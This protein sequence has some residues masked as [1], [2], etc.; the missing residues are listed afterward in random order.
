MLNLS[1][2]IFNHFTGKMFSIGS[3]R[4]WSVYKKI[5]NKLINLISVR[6]LKLFSVFK[7][8]NKLCLSHF[9]PW[10]LKKL[11]R[12]LILDFSLSELRAPWTL[13]SVVFIR[14]SFSPSSQICV[15]VSHTVTHTSISDPG[16][17]S[18]FLRCF[19]KRTNWNLRKNCVKTN[20]YTRARSK[21]C[22]SVFSA[23]LKNY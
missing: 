17:V 8:I 7:N 4:N 1:F 2:L 9:K 20:P 12:V 3:T 11:L 10:I 6:T 18:E 13:S 22:V 5:I 14:V 23:C 15:C 16:Q 19:K 21:A